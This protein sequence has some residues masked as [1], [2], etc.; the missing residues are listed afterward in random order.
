MAHSPSITKRAPRTESQAKEMIVSHMNEDHG[1]SLSDYCQ[2][3]AKIP[4]KVADSAELVDIDLERMTINLKS[5]SEPAGSTVYIPIDPP[6]KSLEEAEVRL[7]EM[8]LESMEALGRSMWKVKKWVAP[9]FP[10]GWAVV[11]AVGFGFYS[12][13]VGSNFEKGAFVREYILMGNDFLGDLFLKYHKQSFSF[14]VFIHAVEAFHMHRTRLLKHDVKP[15]TGVWWA[16]MV[17]TFFEGMGSFL[18]FDNL[19][20]GIRESAFGDKYR[21]H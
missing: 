2:F 10:V 6:M 1:S 17:G 11:S 7:V 12:L 14:M 3:Y 19:V 15:L 21:N 20:A 4:K 8:A 16:W 5:S 9:S 13:A 18:R